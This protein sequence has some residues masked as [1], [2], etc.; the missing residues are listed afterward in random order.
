MEFYSISSWFLI[1]IE[2][3]A[4]I[5]VIVYP[6]VSSKY[7]KK[8][9]LLKE[10]FSFVIL[11]YMLVFINYLLGASYNGLI[12][13][14]IALE[15]WENI[16][17]MLKNTV[18]VVALDINVEPASGLFKV[19]PE[20]KVSFLLGI[21][22]SLIMILQSILS[23]I[24]LSIA[25]KIKSLKLIYDC[26][27]IISFTKSA[28]KYLENNKDEKI[29]IIDDELSKDEINRL[30][31]KGYTVINKNLKS[32]RFP[33]L[34][35]HNQ[36]NLIAFKDS[37]FDYSEIISD[38]E[39]LKKHN[40]HHIMYL[41][42]EANYQD[43]RIIKDKY[44]S[45]AECSEK[46]F[47]RCFNPY[48]ILARGF[49]FD[50]PISKYI[51]R[52]FLN[53]NCTLKNDKEI[54]V[55][56]LGF[57][58]VNSEIFKLMA[59]QNQFVSEDKSKLHAHLVNYYF[60]DINKSNLNNDTF[61]RL[62]Y[63]YN[64]II[65]DKEKEHIGFDNVCKVNIEYDDFKSLDSFKKIVGLVNQKSF[66]YFIVS[67]GE[68]L[69]NIDF[70]IK[71]YEN[72]KK[73]GL[74]KIF[75]RVKNSSTNRLNKYD[76]ELVYFGEQNELFKHESVVGNIFEKFSNITHSLYV[77]STI[78]DINK[79]IEFY[80]LPYI[81]QYSNL[82]SFLSIPFKMGL[83]GLEIKKYD[84]LND[85][86]DFKKIN[87]EEYYNLLLDKENDN[88]EIVDGKLIRNLT[89]EYYLNSLTKSNVLAF[90]E[91]LRW[92]AY[93]FLN[94]FT[95]M[96]YND[97]TFVH[98]K[99]NDSV[100]IQNIDKKEHGC[101]VNYYD[102]IKVHEKQ[103]EVFK[104]HNIEKEFKDV[105]TLHYDFEGFDNIINTLNNQDY[106]LYRII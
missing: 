42:L 62:E 55:V 106:G 71:L 1:V 12:D 99:E 96:N 105:E 93:Y 70:A 68:E 41:H 43:S 8:R 69:E 39:I 53:E 24:N 65:K 34:F 81:K 15:T 104:E 91:H 52:S 18:K 30:L 14:F 87:N 95:P 57:G 36:Y 5:Y 88:Y 7:K 17:L 4:L 50:N 80:N 3:I 56:F 29:V 27:I 76:E 35:F 97:Y 94:N 47:V 11:S 37:N 13:D 45:K 28:E 60:Y 22:L 64:N 102:L 38:F 82:H 100:I 44:I 74:C 46:A 26:D 77:N 66:T 21:L 33:R 51:P 9:I 78:D 59:E 25:N 90:S 75:V 32:L 16:F 58:K 89:K 86:K 103:L 19:L 61:L 54:N 20:Y 92:N 48:E 79:M 85:N 2:A 6:F 73:L 10:I 101:L 23:I 31:S 49:V 83:L 63:E 84:S 67:Y 40:K 98:N 72:V